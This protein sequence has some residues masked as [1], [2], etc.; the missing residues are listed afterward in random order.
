MPQSLLGLP[1][2]NVTVVEPIIKLWRS[3]REP[4]AVFA[5]LS[6]RCDYLKESYKDLGNTKL[7]QTRADVCE[8]VAIRLLKSYT[9]DMLIYVLTNDF[10]PNQSSKSASNL[11]KIYERKEQMEI[12]SMNAL[13]V[14]IEGSAK[15]F[16][17]SPLVQRLLDDIWRGNIVFFASAIDHPSSR[18]KWAYT[19][20]TQTVDRA[21]VPIPIKVATVNHADPH[22]LRLSRLRV[23]RY[24]AFFET[25]IYCVFVFCYSMMLYNDIC[26]SPNGWEILFDFFVIGYTINEVTQFANA[27]SYYF[28]NLWNVF[29]VGIFAISFAFMG[30]RLQDLIQGK[31][32]CSDAYDVL[33]INAMLLWPRLLSS[34]DSLPFFGTF[35][36]I[37]RR[38]LIDST[39]FFALLAVFFLGFLQTFYALG[40]ATYTW[41]Q[42]GDLMLK[43]MLGSQFQGFEAAPNFGPFG[44]PVMILYVAISSLILVTILIAI[45]NESFSSIISNAHEEF[46]FLMCIKTVEQ[47]QSDELFE[48]IPP[49]NLIQLVL[50]YPLQKVLPDKIF[51]KVN[52]AVMCILFLPFL[53]IIYLWE[54]FS[55]HWNKEEA[56]QLLVQRAGSIKPTKRRI[57]FRTRTRSTT[58]APRISAVS[59]VP[60]N[61]IIPEDTVAIDLNQEA[62]AGY[63]STNFLGKQRAE[64]SSATLCESPTQT[65]ET[66]QFSSPSAR[67]SQ[68]ADIKERCRLL[69]EQVQLLVA[70]IR[71]MN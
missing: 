50:L 2:I 16:V 32:T 58:A 40:R 62:G 70:A 56:Q 54:V 48:Y 46:L 42:I 37:I 49:F 47:I 39:I 24:K 7:L 59:A 67:D 10:A 13:E 17:S 28:Q 15:N 27:P 53:L 68:L 20:P 63:G 36:V 31:D 6:A 43:I 45:F 69:E 30:L 29:D 35:L 38:M 71:E 9:P 26:G 41:A 19:L 25:L 11:L 60:P 18:I 1:D 44:P 64:G 14:A 8:V 23:P 61:D 12:A 57:A 4:A 21:K 34:L 22:I 66:E 3:R 51:L 33:A 55:A 52:R 5:W 65:M